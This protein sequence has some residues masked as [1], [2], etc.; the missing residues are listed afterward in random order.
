MAEPLDYRPA[1]PKAAAKS[2]LV[3][4]F[5]GWFLFGALLTFLWALE[6]SGHQSRTSSVI[7]LVFLSFG[8]LVI[9]AIVFVSSVLWLA[10][11]Y[12]WTTARWY[13]FRKHQTNLVLRFRDLGAQHAALRPTMQATARELECHG[14][15]ELGA[16]DW[17]ES[18]AMWVPCDVAI[19]LLASSDGQ[20]L[21]MA[22][23]VRPRSWL[24][25][26]LAIRRGATTS[27]VALTSQAADGRT[28]HTA[29]IRPGTPS[30]I[31]PPW[32]NSASVAACPFEEMLGAHRNRTAEF[33]GG[34]PLRT[35]STFEEAKR[36]IG[37]EHLRE[38][39]F[40]RSVG[41]VT[42]AEVLPMLSTHGP[43]KRASEL[44]TLKALRAAD[45]FDTVIPVETRP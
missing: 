5:I 1:Q 17:E 15:R 8:A 45:G 21:A 43:S 30:I 2:K 7:R 34:V 24:L 41:Y 3:R 28:T 10:L 20:V 40:F 35:L 12:R 18:R 42:A 32:I 14:F 4:G 44:R 39:G 31:W 9:V 19:Q 23:H 22:S 16:Y 33:C 29:L 13:R 36:A 37:E 11:R 27:G 25:R 26:L 6:D 38:A